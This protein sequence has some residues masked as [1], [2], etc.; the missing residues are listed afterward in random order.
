MGAS[1]VIISR[2]S[3]YDDIN[4]DKINNIENNNSLF[5]KFHNEVNVLNSVNEVSA[6]SS[7][8]QLLENI[9]FASPKRIYCGFMKGTTAVSVEGNL[10]PCHRYVGMKNF[11]YGDIYSGENK[12]IKKQILDELDKATMKCNSCFAKYICQRNCIREISGSEVRYTSFSDEFCEKMRDIIEETIMIY[13]EM[14]QKE[15]VVQ[16]H[17]F[18]MQKDI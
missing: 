9:R 4:S 11:C 5:V 2:V 6:N 1:S 15:K 16:K 17:D 10:Y 18:R 13:H 14:I 8:G 12:K 7:L 3:V